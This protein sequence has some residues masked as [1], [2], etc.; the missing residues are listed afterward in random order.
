M[1]IPF[2]NI[3]E[4]PDHLAIEL[5]YLC[6]LLSNGWQ[7][8]DGELIAEAGAFAAERLWETLCVKPTAISP[9]RPGSWVLTGDRLEPDEKIR[10][11]PQTGD[12]RTDISQRSRN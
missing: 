3:H 9:R 6:F 2:I 7:D 12:D 8:Q 5:E 11:R 10:H 4:P 1:P